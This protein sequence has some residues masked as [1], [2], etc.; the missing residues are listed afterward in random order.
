MEQNPFFAQPLLQ[1]TYK[2]RA[3][4]RVWCI[5]LV[6]HLHPPGPAGETVCAVAICPFT[7]FVVA[8]PIPDKSSHSTMRWLHNR[9]VCM[10]GVPVAVRCDLGREFSGRFSEYCRGMGIK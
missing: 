10:F 4:F 3:P 8:D 9:I 5:D 6:T 7:K 1:P 2:L